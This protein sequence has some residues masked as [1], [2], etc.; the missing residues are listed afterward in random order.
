MFFFSLKLKVIKPGRARKIMR[1]LYGYKRNKRISFIK[2]PAPLIN[3]IKL[4]IPLS[5]L[6]FSTLIGFQIV[7]NHFV[8]L[9]GRFFV[10]LKKIAWYFIT[11]LRKLR[12]FEP[13]PEI[14][15]IDFKKKIGT[16]SSCIK[17]LRSS[18]S[19][20]DSFIKLYQN[21]VYKCTGSW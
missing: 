4:P 19:S 21:P 10:F 20:T 14:S 12:I 5:L 9:N 6:S 18:R 11:N 1:S 16:F 2:K 8:L 17:T 13:P 7:F 15:L 3:A